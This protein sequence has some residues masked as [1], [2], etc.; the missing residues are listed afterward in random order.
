MT[1]ILIISTIIFGL[2]SLYFF[3]S[4]NQY[5][6]NFPW[7]VSFI[8]VISY[9]VIIMNVSASLD[10]VSLLWTRWV[11][12]GISCTLLTASMLKIFG[13]TGNNKITALVLTPLI[14]LTG[15][16]AAIAT[17]T[18]FLI[19]FFLIGMV[20]FLALISILRKAS[21]SENKDVLNYM[22][23]GW[24]AFPVIFL[25]SPETFNVISSLPIIFGAYLAADVFT[26][27]IFYITSNKYLR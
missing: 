26:K 13:V 10:P 11:G 17:N 21:V 19:I 6:S 22:Y 7:L 9:L 1:T 27:I 20:P 16:L 18:T 8:T 3:V 25:L 14:M 5:R 12:Y 2:S 4:R 23:F 15:V 24:M